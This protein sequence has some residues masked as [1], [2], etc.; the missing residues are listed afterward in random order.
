MQN[1]ITC[2]G[3][4]G[5]STLIFEWSKNAVKEKLAAVS[6]NYALISGLHVGQASG[7]IKSAVKSAGR[8]CDWLFILGSDVGIR[9]PG[10]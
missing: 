7:A 9:P 4:F 1:M 2:S 6:K 3:D 10:G 5:L 8:F